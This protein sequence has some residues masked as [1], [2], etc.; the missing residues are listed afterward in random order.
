[1]LW[2]PPAA[3]SAPPCRAAA[4][5]ARRRWRLRSEP[6]AT[7]TARGVPRAP[8]GHGVGLGSR[9]QVGAG[10]GGQLD[11]CP[12]GAV[13]GSRLHPVR[14]GRRW[15]LRRLSPCSCGHGLHHG[16]MLWGCSLEDW[17]RQRELSSLIRGRV[18]CE[19]DAYLGSSDPR[20]PC[21]P[22]SRF[23]QTGTVQAVRLLTC[24]ADVKLFSCPLYVVGRGSDCAPGLVQVGLVG[25]RWH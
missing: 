5:S 20:G 15:G 11:P 14:M 8:P 2:A 19:L 22:P 12:W 1:M 7:R 18:P 21:Q 6:W 23:C 9:G 13:R 10:G 16:F 4:S 25:L 24:P 17:R 3:P